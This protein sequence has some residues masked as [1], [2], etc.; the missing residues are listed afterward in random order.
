MKD[1]IDFSHPYLSK[2]IIAY[3]GNKRRLL[4]LI[5]RA[6]QKCIPT[7]NDGATFLDPFAGSGIVSRFAKF[8]NF[9]VLS[10]DWEYYTYII[11]STY[12]ELN[13]EDLQKMFIEYSGID[14]I[15][16]LLNS[17]PEPDVDDQYIAKY[18]SPSKDDI[19]NLNF[20]RERM[21]Y[22]RYNGL[23]IDKIRN[24]IEEIYPE[25]SVVS[26]VKRKRE[27][28]LLIAL[29][30]YEAATHTNTS[31]VFKAYHK[32]F[33]GHNRDALGRIL[34]PIIL[35]KPVLI[36]S[37]FRAQVFQKDAGKLIN[38]SEIKNR[39]FDIVYLD[40]PY[41]QHQYGSNYH[42]L[43]SVSLW[44]KPDISNELNSRGVLI[45]KAAIRKDWV[46]TRSDYCYRDSAV[47]AFSEL[48]RDINA[49]YILISY[50]SEGI[51]PFDNLIKIC[52]EK[53]ELDIVSDEYTKY[54]GGKQSIDRLNE[55]IEFVL[56]INTKEKNTSG[57][58]RKIDILMARKKLG[59]LFKKRYSFQKLCRNFHVDRECKTI[60]LPDS[61]ITISTKDFYELKPELD[62]DTMHNQQIGSLI[63]RLELSI[64]RNREEE[65]KEVID[66]I[67]EDECDLSYFVQKIPGILKKFAHKK[68]R[69]SFHLWMKRA[70]KIRE[71]HPLHFSEIEPDLLRLEELAH[72][73]FSN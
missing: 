56:I 35:E 36:D 13:R 18:Y 67:E 44:D 28:S 39:F 8:L 54:R 40:P 1:G 69:E 30:L 10:N 50:S 12:L 58:I 53:G 34:A 62:L 52:S 65:L 45:E 2:Q 19:E 51:I 41:N 20:R 33:G 72:K 5:Y 31:G 48:I 64:C 17:L 61:S 66:K 3:I 24:K 11:N 68:Y 14:N 27:K 60:A 70:K 22:T 47:R 38:G 32:G 7:I 4:P 23:T 25:E 46:I 73:R 21:F 16:D 55:N 6:I 42:M 9:R 43:N 59:L 63:D 15:L 71:S 37:R 57:S 26:S 49:R 29:L